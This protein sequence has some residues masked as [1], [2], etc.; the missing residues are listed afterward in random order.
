MAGA[1]PFAEPLP[2]RPDRKTLQLCRQVERALTLAL[3]ESASDLV[4]DAQLESVEPA[5][6]AGHLLVTVASRHEDTLAVLQALQSDVG[7]LRTAVA[8]AITRR[9]A[10]ELSFRV[11]RASY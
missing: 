11:L 5:P 4:L 9:R 3:A 1:D 8:H 10:P 6:N 2:R 7:R